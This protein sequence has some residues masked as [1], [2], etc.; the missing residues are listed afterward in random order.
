MKTKIMLFIVLALTSSIVYA[1]GIYELK[2]AM[3]FYGINKLAT[4]E[5]KDVLTQS[6]IE[7]SPYLDDNFING[8]VY[9]VQKDKY[10]NVPMRYNIFNDEVEFK[11]SEGQVQ[12]IATP[13]I[14][15][16]IEINNHQLFYIPYISSKKIKHGF[17]ELVEEGNAS[18]FTKQKIIFKDAE[19]AGAYKKAAPAQFI[20]NGDEYYIQVGKD[21]ALLVTNKK[22]LI[23]IFP[24]H[25]DKVKAFVK[26][27]K[28]KTNKVDSLA[29]L[30][31]YYNSL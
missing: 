28:T 24:D 18:L 3:D 20:N 16:K 4:G 8:T 12:A 27:H 10:V 29:E 21:A 22:D 2:Q 13:E 25:I 6:D 1:Q 14:I 17:F 15:E 30:V 19:T 26:K 9:T 11:N 7:G 5:W 23:N 31:K